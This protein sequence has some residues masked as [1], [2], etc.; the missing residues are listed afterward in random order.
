[1]PVSTRIHNP[2]QQS[3]KIVPKF[4]YKVALQI[5]VGLAA[6][7]LVVVYAFAFTFTTFGAFDDDGYFL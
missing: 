4:P 2:N 6:V 5:A 1:M 3:P 7:G